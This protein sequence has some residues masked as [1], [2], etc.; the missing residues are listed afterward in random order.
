VLFFGEYFFSTERSVN[1]SR[2]RD[3]IDKFVEAAMDATRDIMG[4][5]LFHDRSPEK[6]A[7]YEERMDIVI[8]TSEKILI[9]K[10]K[11][12]N[13]GQG[14]SFY[15]RVA[16][17]KELAWEDLVNS[18]T[19]FLMAGVDTTTN[20]TLWVL[21]HLG[22]YPEIQEKL[23]QE[24]MQ[25]V[26]DGPVTDEHLE[27]L[28]YMRQ[29]IRE[30][31]RVTP[32]MPGS[33]FRILD[34]PL[35]V[36][37]YEIPPGIAFHFGISAVQNDP[38]YVERNDEFLPGRWSK[39]AVAKRVGTPSEIIDSTMIAKPFGHGSR[40]CI[41]WR[42]AQNEI[43]VL[44]CYLLRDWKWSWDPNQQKYKTEM[45]VGTRAVPY[46]SMTMVPRKK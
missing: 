37:G 9:E 29:V 38:R 32:L 16:K 18:L 46:P 5:T 34:H 33:T 17:S 8:Q 22:K 20:M 19:I 4:F 15:E 43:R 27:Q 35:V 26:G 39:E 28:E 1:P 13:F 23:Y 11:K 21:L 36:G 44:L 25:V 24:V 14:L 10:S 41:G 2:T 40:M 7:K 31:H 45:Y 6:I 12:P 42:F 3:D 30:S